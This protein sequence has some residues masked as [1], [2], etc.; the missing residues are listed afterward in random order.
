MRRAMSTQTANRTL[1]AKKV[2]QTPTEVRFE[3]GRSVMPTLPPG[4][5][6]LVGAPTNSLPTLAELN[7]K[8]D[9]SPDFYRQAT[10]E[11]TKRL[12]GKLAL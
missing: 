9:A 3:S 11:N 2:T 1:N 4:Y 7:A 10:T 5:M 6:V 12:T 8:M